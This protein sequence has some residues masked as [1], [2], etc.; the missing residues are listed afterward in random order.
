MSNRYAQAHEERMASIWG[1]NP[2]SK[3]QM[4]IGHRVTKRAQKRLSERGLT[5]L[6]D[7]LYELYADMVED[8]DF[9]GIASENTRTRLLADAWIKEETR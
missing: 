8:G 9:D 7:K 3:T 2:P 5:V 6:Y 1:D 4:R